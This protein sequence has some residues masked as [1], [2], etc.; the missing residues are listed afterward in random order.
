MLC[1]CPKVRFG[2]RASLCGRFANGYADYRKRL[3]RHGRA[4]PANRRR[5]AQASRSN[6]RDVDEERSPSVVAGLITTCMK[7][8][9]LSLTQAKSSR[10]FNTNIVWPNF[11][12][13]TNSVPVF[14]L[15]VFNG[16]R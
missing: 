2:G 4:P 14:A 7:Q 8:R 5:R 13:S 16:R 6:Q 9:V 1:V 11:V 15:E 10:V 3:S 12:K